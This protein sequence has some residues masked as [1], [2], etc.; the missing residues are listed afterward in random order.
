MRVVR[1]SMSDQPEDDPVQRRVVIEVPKT[2]VKTVKSALERLGQ[3]DRTSRITPGTSKD[4][5]TAAPEVSEQQ[6]ENAQD[7]TIPVSLEGNNAT[8][9]SREDPEAT[10]Q[11]PVLKFDAASGQYV[12]PAISQHR[13]RNIVAHDEQGVYF[14]TSTPD[15]SHQ[16]FGTSHESPALKFDVVSGQYV[17]PAVLQQQGRCSKVGIVADDEQRMRI[18]TTIPYPLDRVVMGDTSQGSHDH[19]LKTKI[20][21]NLALSHLFQDISIS[22]QLIPTS[23]MSPVSKLK[24]LQKALKE[25]LEDLPQPPLASQGL[26]VEALV[27]SFPDSYS[28]YRPMLLLPH[29]AFASKAWKSILSAYAAHSLQPVWQRIA[30]A[31]GATH[32]AVNSPIPLQTSTVSATTQQQLADSQLH[33]NILRSPVNISP[34]FGDF[35]PSPTPQTLSSPTDA[36]FKKALWVTT[37]QNGIHQTWAPLYTMFSRGVS[38]TLYKLYMKHALTKYLQI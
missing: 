12:E 23:S 36:D 38:K 1:H 18:P 27:S 20:L 15:E 8:T 33:G 34:L 10:F 35:G 13:G 9:A 16:D 30:E 14:S 26:T 6:R 2:L 31:V 3:L 29:N 24:P 7:D 11:F 5:I 28:V 37:T 22:H 19:E 25:A 4:Q 17:E 32:I 21:E